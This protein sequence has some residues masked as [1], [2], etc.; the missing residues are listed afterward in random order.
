MLFDLYY[1][2]VLLRCLQIFQMFTAVFV[3]Q[4]SFHAHFMLNGHCG[5]DN[6]EIILIDKGRNKQEIRKKSFFG[7]IS[8]THLYHMVSTSA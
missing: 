3:I 4:V 2:L 5:I 6:W 8:L 1:H 7:N